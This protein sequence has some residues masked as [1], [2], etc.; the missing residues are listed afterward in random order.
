MRVRSDFRKYPAMLDVHHIDGDRFNNDVRNLAVL[1]PT[2]HALATRRITTYYRNAKD[3]LCW[4]DVDV[5]IYKNREGKKR[6]KFR[7]YSREY[8][9]K[10]R[11]KADAHA[12]I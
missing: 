10:R 6:E 5:N 11:R 4:E 8:M 9:R 3:V 12:I 1:C 7:R 2:C